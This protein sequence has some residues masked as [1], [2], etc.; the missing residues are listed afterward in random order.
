MKSFNVNYGVEPLVEGVRVVIHK[1]GNDVKIKTITGI[2]ITMSMPDT[3][4]QFLKF[5]DKDFIFDAVLKMEPYY[6]IETTPSTILKIMLS[7]LILTHHTPKIY[8]LDVLYFNKDVRKLSWAERKSIINRLKYLPVDV[9]NLYAIVV[10]NQE[11]IVNAINTCSMLPYSSGAVV[12]S[13]NSKYLDGSTMD[14][15]FEVRGVFN[16]STIII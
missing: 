4:N 11:D 12:K 3:A 15:Y 6:P 13:F 2:D 10:S 16:E 9:K 8:I 14:L 5:K 1:K 7:Q